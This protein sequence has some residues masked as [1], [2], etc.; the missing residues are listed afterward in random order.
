[1]FAMADSK[2]RVSVVD[3]TFIGNMARFLN[4]SCNVTIG[5]SQ[6]NCEAKIIKKSKESTILIYTIKK[7]ERYEE[8]TYD[9]QFKKENK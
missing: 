5:L 8:L 3:A 9:Y 2:E 4:H 7:I 6:P 1:M